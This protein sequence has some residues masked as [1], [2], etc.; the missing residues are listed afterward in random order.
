[1]KKLAILAILISILF[2]PA[3]ASY[4]EKV[5]YGDATIILTG[6]FGQAQDSNGIT[7][8]AIEPEGKI[9]VDNSSGRKYHRFQIKILNVESTAKLE[10]SSGKS[11][12]IPSL[13]HGN[14]WLSFTVTVEPGKSETYKF[15]PPVPEKTSF[16]FIVFGDNR[17]GP[18]ILDKIIEET[19][20]KNP[21]FC[22][23]LGDL[24]PSGKES[25]Y[26]AFTAQLEKLNVPVYTIPGNHDVHGEGRK[27][28]NQ[29]LG[30]DYYSFNYGGCRFLMLDN[31]TGGFSAEEYKWLDTD[32]KEN[33]SKHFL[34]FFHMPTYSIYPRYSGHIMRDKEEAKKFMELAKKE[35]FLAV[36]TG[37]LH[38]YAS[39][40]RDGTLYVTSGGAGAPLHST[41]FQGGF[42]HYI[43][44][45]IDKGSINTEVIQVK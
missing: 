27:F 24:V 16:T 44:V 32:L 15:M 2:L 12:K 43:I 34:A 10:N 38:L 21:V 1:M 26:T 42:Y 7:I 3:Y 25:Q 28:Y 19:N 17:D 14:N 8:R 5:T 45:K 18:Q 30:P 31:S 37:H 39:E 9:V 23:D 20:K 13:A 11:K 4:T 36:F 6:A 41:P 40:K 33:K 35:H 22:I 29:L